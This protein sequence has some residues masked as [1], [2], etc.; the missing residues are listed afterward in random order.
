MAS[1]TTS[2][3]PRD[4]GH[5]R[6]PSRRSDEEKPER[7]LTESLS[8]SGGEQPREITVWQ[9]RAATS[10]S[11]GSSTSEKQEGLPRDR[12]RDRI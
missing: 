7:A 3:P 4:E 9:P 8:G 11:T 1:G 10:E 2:R 5:D 12:R 6:T